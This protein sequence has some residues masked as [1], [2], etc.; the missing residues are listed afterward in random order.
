MNTDK[1]LIDFCLWFFALCVLVIL[2]TSCNP[3]VINTP[4]PSPA[5]TVLQLS[6]VPTEAT[7]APYWQL[8]ALDAW[9]SIGTI[10]N[11]KAG[12]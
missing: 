10:S 6:P 4:T 8:A 7:P 2:I 1:K 3:Y 11:S 12:Y 5:A 9:Q